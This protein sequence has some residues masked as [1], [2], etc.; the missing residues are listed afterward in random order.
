MNNNLLQ[1]LGLQEPNTLSHDEHPLTEDT[2]EMPYG[3][4]DELLNLRADIIDESGHTTQISTAEY[5][6]LLYSSPNEIKSVLLGSHQ[7]VLKDIL[8]AL[9]CSDNS[10]KWSAYNCRE[11]Y[12]FALSSTNAIYTS[13]TT[14]DIDIV[15]NVLRKWECPSVSLGMKLNVSKLQK[16]NQ[17]VFILGH[18]DFIGPKKS[19][20]KMKSLVDL[21]LD[22]LKSSVPVDVLHVALAQF[23]FHMKLPL[24]MDKLPLPMCYEIP[25]DPG[26][27]DVFSYPEFNLRRQQLEPRIINPSHVLTN[28]RLHATQKGI[29]GCDPNAFVRVS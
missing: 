10:I 16:A 3:E 17:L 18:T 8:I 4:D 6:T 11:F 1:I 19:K 15:I 12:E 7:C 26:T 22:E 2:D 27:F 20:P 28:L 5:G 29:L 25:I 24:W 21:M 14:H 23:D 13:K 9:L